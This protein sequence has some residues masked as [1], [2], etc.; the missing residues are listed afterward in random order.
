MA[1]AAQLPLD[2]QHRQALG[3]DDFLI[4]PNNQDAVRWID[5]WPEWPAPCLIV[6]GPPASGK[7]H[8]ASVWASMSDAVKPAPEILGEEAADS[9]AA[10]G[11]HLVMDSVDPWFGDRE[12]ETK[13]FHLYNMFKE[14]GRSLLITMRMAP[15][16]ADIGLPDLASRL[17]AAPAACIAPPDDTL[18]A[19]LMVK[20]FSDR[21]LQIGQDVL[22]YILPRMERS[23][24]AA[25]EL[26]T[27]A[28]RLALAEK[29]SIS[30]P[31]IR[32]ILLEQ[33]DEKQ[34]SFLGE[35][36]PDQ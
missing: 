25:Q 24:A 12:A 5:R 18:L 31:L 28:D 29:K 6:Y 17:R 15:H 23:F 8:L 7:S 35:F 27:L 1:I 26:V 9:I 19:A 22:N 36:F 34:G 11:H 13:L 32:R 4:A 21:Q 14:E 10:K 2:L 33:E 20:L 30:I 16:H 3:R